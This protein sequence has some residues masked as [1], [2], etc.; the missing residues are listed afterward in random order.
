DAN[1]LCLGS[2]VVGIGLAK[3]VLDIWCDSSFEGG[4]HQIRIDKMMNVY[5]GES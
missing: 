5:R 1:V 4:R 3:Q 2:R